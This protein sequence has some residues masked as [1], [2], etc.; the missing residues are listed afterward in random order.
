MSTQ[1]ELL[2]FA[3]TQG[4]MQTTVDSAVLT[5][6]PQRDGA[7]SPH[8][9]EPLATTAGRPPGSA[10]PKRA[11]SL[12]FGTLDVLEETRFPSCPA[13]YAGGD[14]V[15]HALVTAFGLQR[16]EPSNIYNDHRTVPS[17]RSKFPVHAFVARGRRYHWLDIYR[18]A[19]LDMGVPASPP[20]SILLAARYS[21]LPLPYG[22]LRGAL[23]ELELGINLRALC[24]GLDLFEIP[25]RVDP[26]DSGSESLLRD[27]RLEPAWAWTLPVTISLWPSG[28]ALPPGSPSAIQDGPPDDALLREVVAMNRLAALSPRAAV[29]SRG[30]SVPKAGKG[31]VSWAEV[32]WTRSSGTMP[33]GLKGLAGRRQVRPFSFV[34]DTMDWLE[35][36]PPAELFSQVSDELTVTAGLQ[37][38]EGIANGIY[39]LADGELTLLARH[40]DIGAELELDYGHPQETDVGCG[41]RVANANWFISVRPRRLISER[42]PWAWPLALL[43]AGW[44]AQGICLAAAAHG[45]HARPSRA[46]KEILLQ[47]LLQLPPDELLLISVTCGTSRFAES[48]LDLRL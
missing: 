4:S 21:D 13:A 24:A 47:P 27:L 26:P 3:F 16:R 9:P 23:T 36:T 46:F 42:G 5:R 41:V 35:V 2:R 38:I 7:P 10:D 29:A 6:W 37:D 34:R 39:R 22:R 11:T 15:G 43:A 1:E 30:R 12:P 40:D 48:T 14:R 17:V 8:T 18:H 44:M 31:S 45:L 33:R 20:T 25:Y 32:L 28:D 19:L